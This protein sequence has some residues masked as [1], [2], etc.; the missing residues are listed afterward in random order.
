MIKK[1]LILISTMVIF[2]TLG[3]IININPTPSPGPSPTVTYAPSPSPT[4]TYAPSPTKE[5][6]GKLIFEDTDL[7]TPPGQSCAS[8]HAENAGYSDPRTDRGVSP[9]IILGRYGL[10]KSPRIQ[11]D[12]SPD[13]HF[14]PKSL[15][16]E[17]GQF[18]DGR[19]PNLKDQVKR[20]ILNSLEMNNPDQAAVVE[21][22]KH[23]SIIS[24]LFK[25]VYGDNSLEDNDIAYDNMADALA[26]YIKSGYL[27]KFTSKFDYYTEGKVSLNEDEKRGFEL[28]KKYC[29][30]CH[31]SDS[32]PYADRP[33]F[34]D[35][36]YHNVGVPSN[37]GM[38]GDTSYLQYYY[39]FYYPPLVPEFN[40]DGL[41]FADPGLGGTLEKANYPGN[42]IQGYFG[43]LG[44][45]K[46]PSLRNVV[47][48]PPYFHN[49][50][51]KTLK[52]V[53]HF[54][55]T[56]DT[57]GDCQL[58]VDPHPGI[59]CWPRS[60]WS[61]NNDTSIGH[62]GLSENDE[63]DIVAFLK[64]LTDDFDISSMKY[65]PKAIPPE[66]II[67]PAVANPKKIPIEIK[68]TT[69]NPKKIPLKN[70]EIDYPSISI[71][72]KPYISIPA[73][74]PIETYPTPTV[75]STETYVIY[76]TPTVSPTVSPTVTYPTPTV[77]PTVTYPT[78]TVSPTVSPTVTYPTPTVSPTV[79]PT[80]TY[81]TPT[82]SPTVSPTV[83]YP[84]PTVSPTET[85]PTPTV[86]P[87]VSPTVTYPTPTV[88]PTE[89]YVT[90]PT[91]TVSPTETYPTPTPTVSPTETY[92][93]Y[94]TPTVSPT[95]TY[96]TPTPTVS[97]TE[98]YPTPTP[99]YPIPKVFTPND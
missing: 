76:P 63:N 49:G 81:P 72:I 84:T 16:F 34:T 51:L 74:S 79:S 17:G 70:I 5:K 55:N 26:T 71:K 14:N 39:P 94:P 18:R 22:I 83:T 92:V 31:P 7:S 3:C 58:K 88:S 46:V 78:P 2:F 82:V 61:Q 9:G 91:P 62:F 32:G 57:L 8:C 69:A 80:V 42:G 64:I 1:F 10:R 21:K 60:E 65:P 43:Q 25:Q 33:L 36:T 96:P 11:Y 30:P 98:T 35:F 66:I 15:T 4:V 28:F 47:K 52:E 77:S 68:Y 40:P 23:S 73:P 89:T 53:V 87:T 75:S 19:S 13:F 37:L 20:P 6:L 12:L 90:Y 67:N 48:S 45:F 27:I 56:R 99:T 86:S 97:P 41:N 24:P 54:Y 93:T 50:A 38:L 59:N 85:Y 29:T 44:K 95:E